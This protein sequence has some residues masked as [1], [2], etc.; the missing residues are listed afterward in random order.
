MPRTLFISQR[1]PFARKVRILLAEKGLAHDVLH[2]DL[3][4]R[5]PELL[6][7]SP[8]WKV[9]VLIDEDGTVVFDSTVIAEYLEDRYPSPPLLGTG[10]VERLRHRAVE[11]LGDTAL[12][13]TI[14]LFFHK[15]QGDALARHERLLDSS[16]DEIARRIREGLAPDGFGL[17]HAAVIAVLDY[18]DLR[19][20]PARRNAHPELVRFV[21]PHLER[22]SVLQAPPPVA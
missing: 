16:L 3:T 8:L 12:E 7:V 5:S 13:Q 2:E 4:A 19:L 17:A 1:S 6:S 21:A 15:P 10:F 18:V 20:G 22:P 9:P 14:A 11:D